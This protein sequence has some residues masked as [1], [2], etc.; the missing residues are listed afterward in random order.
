MGEGSE[1]FFFGG[2]EGGGGEGRGSDG[3]Q[4][5]NHNLSPSFFTWTYLSVCPWK[6]YSA[7][8]KN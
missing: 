5:I 1:D 2:G 4:A 8:A 6:L 7:L 3:L